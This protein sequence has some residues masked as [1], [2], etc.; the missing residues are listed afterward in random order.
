MPP[1]SRGLTPPVFATWSV[2]GLKQEVPLATAHYRDQ[3]SRRWSCRSLPGRPLA[4]RGGRSNIQ[5][6]RTLGRRRILISD[7]YARR[8]RNRAVLPTIQQTAAAIETPHECSE[9]PDFVTLSIGA[10]YG[11]TPGSWGVLTCVDLADQALYTA[12]ANGRNRYE[13]IP[14][15]HDTPGVRNGGAAAAPR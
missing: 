11:C 8:G 6:R 14:F 7:L 3:A 1:K 9:V 10:C 4:E 13:V 5:L 12:K 15:S 2:L